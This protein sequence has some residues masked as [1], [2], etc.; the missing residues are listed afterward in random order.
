MAFPQC[1]MQDSTAVPWRWKL[2]K[3]KEISDC[4]RQ[5]D[6]KSVRRWQLS[7]TWSDFLSGDR[8]PRFPFRLLRT[9]ANSSQR[10]TDRV[11]KHAN[12]SQEWLWC[13]RSPSLDIV[14]ENPLLSWDGNSVNQQTA[15]N[16]CSQQ[17]LYFFLIVPTKLATVLTSPKQ[18]NAQLLLKKLRG[19]VE[20]TRKWEWLFK[21]SSLHTAHTTD[22]YSE[23]H[24][25]NPPLTWT[26]ACSTYNGLTVLLSSKNSDGSSQLSRNSARSNCLLAKWLRRAIRRS[27]SFK[28]LKV[29]E[30]ISHNEHKKVISHE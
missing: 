12:H 5:N 8:S 18:N 6:C 16:I 23:Q 15:A 27:L 2:T 25:A 21:R 13:Q 30:E 4:H 9:D 3:R 14:S 22:H 24:T 19:R 20:I 26:R 7:E 17:K 29:T 1:D 11:D 10:F 28:S